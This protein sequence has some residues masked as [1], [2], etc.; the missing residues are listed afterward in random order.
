MAYLD[1]LLLLLG[2]T[3]FLFCTSTA[4]ARVT[5]RS[6]DMSFDPLNFP[7]VEAAVLAAVNRCNPISIKENREFMGIIV[8]DGN[9]Y[10]YTV[11]RGEIGADTVSIKIT[12]DDWPNV[13]AFWHT[14]GEAAYDYQFFSGV[15]TAIVKRYNK[16]FYLADYT[17][18]LKVFSPGDKTLS[19]CRARNMGLPFESGFATGWEVKDA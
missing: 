12:G 10:R 11:T 3:L 8:R 13:V 4:V 14:H 16:P 1:R 5:E 2:I 17:G 9:R 6:L 7:T 15:D 18:A 19:R